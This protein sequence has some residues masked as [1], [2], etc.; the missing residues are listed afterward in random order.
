MVYN[1]FSFS[2]MASIDGEKDNHWKDAILYIGG[3]KIEGIKSFRFM[4]SF[5][6]TYYLN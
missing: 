5:K 1:S 6:F 3:A 2:L 4:H